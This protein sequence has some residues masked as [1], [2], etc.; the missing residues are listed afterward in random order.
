MII[1][2]KSQSRLKIYLSKM[3]P[4]EQ[5]IRSVGGEIGGLFYDI[6]MAPFTLL[7]FIWHLFVD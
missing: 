3:D 1:Q 5:E 2:K 7:S 6:I 4:I